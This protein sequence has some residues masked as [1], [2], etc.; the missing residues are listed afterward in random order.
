M[1]KHLDDTLILEA[2]D[3]IEESG[4]FGASDRSSS[5]LRYLVTEELAGRGDRLKAYSVAIDV[6]ERDESFNPSSNSLV[7]VEAL[8]L[9]TALEQYYSAAGKDEQVRIVLKPGSYR[10][11]LKLL[12]S[13]PTVAVTDHHR[14]HIIRAMALLICV[15]IAIGLY[16][17][18]AW[19]YET[20]FKLADRCS[21]ARPYVRVSFTRSATISP[22]VI[23]QW[24]ATMKRYLGAYPLINQSAASNKEC[25]GIPA[26]IVKIF[27]SPASANEISAGLTT[28]NGDFVWSKT[29]S[30]NDF[31]IRDD[32]NIGLAKVA[33]DIGYTTG[34]VTR[35]ALRRNWKQK[36]AFRQY[37]CVT[38]IAVYVGILHEEEFQ[39]L[40]QCLREAVANKTQAA[41]VYGTLA[42]LLGQ[43]TIG[44]RPGNVEE[45]KREREQ[46]IIAGQAI[47]PADSSILTAKLKVSQETYPDKYVVVSEVLQSIDRWYP[48]QPQVLVQAALSYSTHGDYENA[49][50]YVARA[51]AIAGK[52]QPSY[53]PLVRSYIGL[54]QWSLA[55]QYIDDIRIWAIPRDRITLL[56]IAQNIG[57]RA[58]V[59][60]ARNWLARNGYSS[61]RLILLNIESMR[62]HHSFKQALSDSVTAAFDESEP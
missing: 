50:H 59:R 37:D 34:P 21:S 2:I 32:E 13:S 52:L 28:A 9:R 49:I 31:V 7:R 44:A 43:I 23:A 40:L 17:A 27:D 48:M 55:A 10:P 4:V 36:E 57:D 61:K 45:A 29:Y 39:R 33:Y 62:T 12:Q 30:R 53:G 22:P 35:D 15:A 38:K 1:D 51:E 24:E 54:R 56:A 47:N 42:L 8:R 26:Y 25:P 14:N 5:L 58:T 16:Y 18:A 19:V 41:D 11:D 46:L 6:F 20:K 3:R 60:F